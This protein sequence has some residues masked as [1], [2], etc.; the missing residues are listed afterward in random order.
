M[1]SAAKTG[2]LRTE[3]LGAA[4]PQDETQAQE[5]SIDEAAGGA[6]SA[7][8]LEKESGDRAGSESEAG[9]PEGEKARRGVADQLSV[10]EI[11]LLREHERRSGC[12]DQHEKMIEKVPDIQEEKMQA[13]TV[14]VRFGPKNFVSMRILQNANKFPH[15]FPHGCW[16]VS[17]A[18]R[19]A[20]VLAC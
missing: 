2:G 6:G 8:D 15:A 13:V 12:E 7:D 1:S 10:A 9:K 16:P 19:L 11:P 3:D 5:E 20:A 14:H 17:V 18:G 4:Q